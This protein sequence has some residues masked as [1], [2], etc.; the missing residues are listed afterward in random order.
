MNIRLIIFIYIIWI[1]ILCLLCM[2]WFAFII[3]C[4]LCIGSSILLIPLMEIHITDKI[5]ENEFLRM[6]SSI[7]MFIFLYKIFIDSMPECVSTITCTI[8]GIM[9]ILTDIVFFILNVLL[10][11][12]GHAD[13]KLLN[14]PSIITTWKK[15]LESEDEFLI[16]QKHCSICLKKFISKSK[17]HQLYCKHIYHPGCLILWRRQKNTCPLCFKII[18]EDIKT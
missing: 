5:V 12:D 3:N 11:S 16:Q 17:I 6:L 4:V 10:W 9:I 2:T 14:K 1:I 13:L 15:I 7:A 18:D 8:K